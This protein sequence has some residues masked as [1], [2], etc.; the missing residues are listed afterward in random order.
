[1]L[2]SAEKSEKSLKFSLSVN[3]YCRDISVTIVFERGG[4]TADQEA[5]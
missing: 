3:H 5:E 2:D 4:N 1:M